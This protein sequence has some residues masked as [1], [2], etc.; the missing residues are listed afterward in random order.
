MR[1]KVRGFYGTIP[2]N[3]SAGQ[4]LTVASLFEQKNSAKFSQGAKLKAFTVIISYISF[5]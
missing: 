4:V 2:I 5:C 1:S 3:F